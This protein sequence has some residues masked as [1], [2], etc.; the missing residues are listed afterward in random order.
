VGELWASHVFQQYL[1]KVHSNIRSEFLNAREVIV[2]EDSLVGKEV[3]MRCSLLIIQILWEITE[4]K[5]NAWLEN[6]GRTLFRYF[7]SSKA[8]LM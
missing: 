5:V 8:I 4:K 3:G 7:S 6:K 2:A 1:A